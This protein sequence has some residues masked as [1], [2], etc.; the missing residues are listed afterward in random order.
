M[1]IRRHPPPGIKGVI[2]HVIHFLRVRFFFYG[3]A[4]HFLSV[5][6]SERKLFFQAVSSL[7]KAKRYFYIPYCNTKHIF[8]LGKNKFDKLDH[9]VFGWL[10]RGG[11]NSFEVNGYIKQSVAQDY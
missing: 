11:G 10:V 6:Q 7:Q 4:C 8:R 1:L 3:L 2:G 9:P 5:F